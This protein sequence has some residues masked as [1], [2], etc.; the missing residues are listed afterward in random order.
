MTNRDILE[1]LQEYPIIA[2]IRDEHGLEKAIESEVKVVFILS[3]NLLDIKD[4]VDTIRSHGK[5]T[6]VHLDLIGGLGRDNSAVDFLAQH[7]RPD[8]YIT[9]KVSLAKY[10]KQQGLFVVQRLFIIDSLSLATGIKSIKDTTPDAIEVMPGIAS[11]LIERLK[12]QVSVPIIAGGLIS[13]KSDII[14]T[15]STGVLAISTSSEGLWNM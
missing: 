1:S 9:T 15:L 10:A 4:T 3:G 11:K 5:K 12:K 6:L 14:E 13:S 7:A 2:A 8:G